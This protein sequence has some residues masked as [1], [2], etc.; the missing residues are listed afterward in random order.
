MKVS[1]TEF[2]DAHDIRLCV[3][4]W[5]DADAP[6]LF[7]IHGWM[8]ISASFQFVVDA[9]T[10]DWHVIAP[11]MRGFGHSAWAQGGYWFPDY[12]AD[13]EALL[14][15]YSPDAPVRLLGHSLGGNVTSV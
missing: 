14:D 5:G 1:R 4:H 8:D 9:L 15:H 7:M 2:V 6:K 3:R 13:L 11:D 12:L 10:R